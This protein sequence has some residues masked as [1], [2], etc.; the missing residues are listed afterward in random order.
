[1]ACNILNLKRDPA[2]I[3]D[4][5]GT[6]LG[7]A[8]LHSKDNEKVQV[9]LAPLI[10]NSK[11]IRIMVAESHFHPAIHG[12]LILSCEVSTEALVSVR[13][14]LH[15]GETRISNDNIEEVKE[16]LSML[17]VN[18]DI[19]QDRKKKEYLEHP[20]VRD[21]GV[22]LEQ[23][24]KM[25]DDNENCASEIDEELNNS[26]KKELIQRVNDIGNE[27]NQGFD[28]K[29]KEKD[30]NNRRNYGH[31][32]PDASD[33]EEITMKLEINEDNF[34]FGDQN[35]DQNYAVKNC[36]VKSYEEEK[37]LECKVCHYSASSPSVLKIHMRTH[38]G[39]K[40]YNCEMCSSAFRQKQHLKHHMRIHT[41]EKPYTCVLCSSAFRQKQHLKDHMRIHTGEKPYTCDICSSTFRH[42]NHFKNHMK[43][44]TENLS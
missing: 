9:T 1:M 41:G 27:D 12:P 26:L 40:P 7:T 30:M 39:E 24:F 10:S 6:T 21:G 3:I 38:T 37:L 44:H 33:G 23:D 14:I 16:V 28:I 36:A 25:Q 43:K 5:I 18:A 35:H 32:E 17:G 20:S 29:R 13:D 22:K 11:L 8:T 2:S 19:N 4:L 42:I 15:T 34:E 31:D